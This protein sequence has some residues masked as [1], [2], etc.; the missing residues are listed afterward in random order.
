MDRAEGVKAGASGKD[1]RR[2]ARQTLVVKALV[3]RDREGGPPLRATLADISLLGIAFDLP[4]RLETGSRCR[5]RVEAGPMQLS[6]RIRITSCRQHEN[7]WRSGAEFVRN[8]IEMPERTEP[9]LRPR[10]AGLPRNPSRD[11]A[12]HPSLR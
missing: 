10:P 12:P 6:A 7:G 9:D 1:R 11:L 3:T 8:E 4:E 2:A 5:I